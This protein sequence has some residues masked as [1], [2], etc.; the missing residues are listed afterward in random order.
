MR[1]EALRLKGASAWTRLAVLAWT[2]VVAFVCVRSLVQPRSRTLFTTW[3]QAGR[4]WEQGVPLYRNWWE[5]HQDQYRYSPLV[6]V[7]LVPFAH[8]PEGLGGAIWRLL[9]AGVFLVGL[10]WWLRVGVPRAPTAA[11]RAIIFLLALPLSLSSL[12]NGQPN[13]LIIGLLLCA[14]AALARERWSLAAVLVML[15]TALKIYPLAI[16]LLLAA[17]YPRRFAPRLVLALAVGAL[18]PFLCQRWGY[19]WFQYRLW[20]VKLDVDD[21]WAWPPHMSYRDLWQLLRICQVSITP[22]TYRLVQLAL[23]AGAALLVVALRWRGHERRE[24][25]LA[26]VAL[27]SCWMTVVGPSAESATYVILTPALAYAALDATRGPWAS[28]GIAG[29]GAGWWPPAVRWLPAVSWWLF[30]AA[31]LAGLFPTPPV[32]PDP[33]RHPMAVVI[34][35]LAHGRSPGTNYLHALGLH[36]MAALVLTAAYTVAILR[37]LAAAPPAAVGEHAPLP[38]RAA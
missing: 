28:W 4:D 31:V 32:P 19:V 16:G 22:E 2:A 29:T 36:A 17:A 10:G 25:L 21:R 12:N 3:A 11:G 20:Y 14:G 9:N 5:P 34:E 30:F 38:A 37:A 33:T 7:L 24:V 23:A 8:V 15:A 18:L 26:A 27:G 6:A 35:A 13:P 1:L